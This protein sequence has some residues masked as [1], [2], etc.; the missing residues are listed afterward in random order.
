MCSAK[1]NWMA[2]NVGLKPFLFICPL[3]LFVV[4]YSRVF[5]RKF[6]Y[7]RLPQITT[8]VVFVFLCYG[9]IFFGKQKRLYHQVKREALPASEIIFF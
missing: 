5:L 1:R 6:F 9:S 3:A 2:A 4:L 8:Q 7:I